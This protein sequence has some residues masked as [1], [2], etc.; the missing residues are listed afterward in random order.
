MDFKGIINTLFFFAVIFVLSSLASAGMSPVYISDKLNRAFLASVGL[1]IIGVILA[2]AFIT[3]KLLADSIDFLRGLV[4]KFGKLL[5]II[6]SIA[7]IVLNFL[8][9]I[10]YPAVRGQVKGDIDYSRYNGWCGLLI[11]GTLL[12]VAALVLFFVFGRGARSEGYSESLP[13]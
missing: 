10:I 3:V 8:A 13:N 6:V 11:I 5:F 7:M 2:C 4:E 1:Q 9:V 12:D